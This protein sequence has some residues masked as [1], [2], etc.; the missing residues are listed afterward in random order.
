M[1]MNLSSIL[2][3][4]RRVSKSTSLYLSSLSYLKMLF[5]ELN[6]LTMADGSSTATSKIGSFSEHDDSYR[7]ALFELCLETPEEL[8]WVS[9]SPLSLMA[10][11]FLRTLFVISSST[12]HWSYFWFDFCTILPWL[13]LIIVIKLFSTA[14]SIKSSSWVNGYIFVP[15]LDIVLQDS[16]D[17]GEVAAIGEKLVDL[18]VN[19]WDNHGQVTHLTLCPRFHA[20][21]VDWELATSDAQLL[22][23]LHLVGVF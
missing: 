15:L 22:L 20:V 12:E 18:L 23:F 11:D 8:I 10:C 16:T 14:N 7:K 2:E 6:F 1:P 3:S 19:R 17:L 4:D 13:L 21:H 9:L 5:K